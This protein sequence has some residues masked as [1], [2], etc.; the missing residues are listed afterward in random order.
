MGSEQEIRYTPSSTETRT[1]LLQRDFLSLPHI[2]DF[3]TCEYRLQEQQLPEWLQDTDIA[4]F[5]TQAGMGHNRVCMDVAMSL[6]LQQPAT[7][8]RRIYELPNLL[9]SKTHRTGS[10]N[11]LARS[12]TEYMQRHVSAQRLSAFAIHELVLRHDGHTVTSAAIEFLKEA[13]NEHAILVAFHPDVAFVLSHS[14]QYLKQ[15]CNKDIDVVVVMTDHLWKRPQ[16][17]WYPTEADLLFVPDVG[18]ADAALSQFFV[19]SHITHQLDTPKVSTIPFPINPLLTSELET[20]ES[21]KRKIQLEPN[22]PLTKILIPLG[23]SAPL[24]EYLSLLQSALPSTYQTHVLVKSSP[25]TKS[26]ESGMKE[27]HALV[28]IKDSSQATLN[29]FLQLY[30]ELL[31]GLVITKPSELHSLALT[32]P[33]QVGGAIILFTPPIGDQEQQNVEWLRA[34]GSLPPRTIRDR[35]WKCSITEMK[36][37]AAQAIDWRALELPPDPVSSAYFISK[38]QTAGILSSMAQHQTMYPVGS[39]TGCNGGVEFWDILGKRL[40]P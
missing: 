30:R 24:K 3:R 8:L 40:Q 28:H 5:S 6:V 14:K 37:F 9:A 15:V 12:W 19:W 13:K 1:S 22:S 21:M 27:N 33:T 23:G 31:P 2:E 26:F 17:I 29:A 18:S 35:L 16:F 32:V 25:Y 34:H 38:V 4:F 20:S 36:T 10:T 11:S 7:A 39:E